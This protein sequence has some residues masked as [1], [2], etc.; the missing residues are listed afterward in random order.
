M[1]GKL[2][3]V[4]ICGSLRRGSYNAM[5]VRTLPALAP[6]EMSISP[7]PSIDTMPL[8]NFDVQ[9]EQGFPAPVTAL[10]D[11]IRAAAGIII[12]TPEYNYSIPGVLKNAIDW[13]SRLPSQPFSGKP[14]AIQSASPSILGGARAQYHLRQ[15]L[16]FLD[17]MV[18][19][20]P[21]I[22]I[23]FANTKVDEAQGIVTDGATRKIISQQ[24]EG[25][26]RFISLVTR[27]A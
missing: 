4:A 8:Y 12:V 16:V 23:T 20:R 17:A 24:L 9:T 11:A 13:L 15:S 21:E 3:V 26:A 6:P 5:V 18:F 1:N 2:N 22:M 14:V 27:P 10:A 19:N 25:F 7:A